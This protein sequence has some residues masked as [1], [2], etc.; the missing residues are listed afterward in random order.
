MENTVSSAALNAAREQL[1][2]AE[3]T[4]RLTHGLATGDSSC[5]GGWMWLD[6]GT[7]L[8]AQAAGLG[9]LTG[10]IEPGKAASARGEP[11]PP[12]SIRTAKI[13]MVATTTKPA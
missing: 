13:A 4:Q 2:A 3:A 10:A 9:Q 1:D 6:H 11:V 12:A 5:G 7:H 8:G